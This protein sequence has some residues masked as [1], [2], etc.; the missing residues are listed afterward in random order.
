[1]SISLWLPSILEGYCGNRDAMATVTRVTEETT[2]AM[3]TVSQRAIFEASRHEHASSLIAVCV[4]DE[5][6]RERM[7]V[8][9][10]SHV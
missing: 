7:C 2:V 8:F 4:C 6:K 5:R 1:M 3:E 10:L 9:L